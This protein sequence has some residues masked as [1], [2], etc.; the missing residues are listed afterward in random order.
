MKTNPHTAASSNIEP[1]NIQSRKSKPNFSQHKLSH[2]IASAL[3]AATLLTALPAHATEKDI[4]EAKEDFPI[5]SI[6]IIGRL[7]S[8]ASEAMEERREQIA[9]ADIMGIEQLAR[10]GDSD[11]A[12][13]LRRVTGLT[14][15][16]GKFIYV[17]GLGERYSS[18]SLNGAIVPSPDPTRNVVP[19][20]MFPSSVIES[21]SVQKSATADMPAAFGGGH[22][23]IRT[24]S[25][26]LEPFF[27]VAVGTAHNTNDSND[28][29]SYRGGNDNSG[30]DDGLR[31]LPSS[32]E[33]TY[34]QYG[35]ISP[36]DIVTGSA[37]N[38]DFTAAQQLNR[39][40]ALDIYRDMDITSEDTDQGANIDLAVGSNWDIGDESVFGVLAAASYKKQAKNYTKREVELDGDD[41]QAQIENSKNVNG[42]DASVRLSA[43]LNLGFELN[44]D[45]KIETFTTYLR[46]TSDDVSISIEE[47]V[48]TLGEPNALQVYGVNYEERSLI[49]NQIKGQH[50]LSDWWDLELAWQYSDA[51][52][53]R[54]APNELGYTYNVL[55]DDNDAITSRHLNTQDAPKYVYSQLDDDTINYGWS[56]TLPLEFDITMVNVKGGYQYFERTR[57]SNA[58]R[59]GF[60]VDLRPSD[61]DGNILAQSFGDI[62]SDDNITND[63]LG[64]ELQDAS[65]DTED[66]VAAEIIDAAFVSVDL[67]IDDEWRIYA[68]LRYEDFRRVTL[69]IDPDGDISDEGGRYQITDYIIKQDD[70]YPS[71][72]LTWVESDET[73]WRLGLSKTVVRPDLR[74]VSPV[75][76]QDPVTGFDFFG[77]P[78]LESS[79]IYNLDARWEWY[80][81][82]GNSFSVG[83]FYKDIDAP[84]E[85]I[86]RISEAGRQLKFYNADSGSIYGIEADFLQHLDVLGD[87]ES[88]W[89]YFF[90]TGNVTLSDSEINIASSGE[91]DPTNQT[92]RMTGHSQW[93][94]NLQLSFDSPSEAHSATLVYNVFGE[95]IAY[96]GRGGLDDV[97][98]QPFHSLDLSYSYFPTDAMAIKLK[99]QNLLDETAEYLQQG[100]QVYAKD[101]GS[102]YSLQFSYKF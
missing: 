34:N 22:V 32:I 41:Q 66:Y 27:S 68:G 26:P 98:E 48:D 12:A 18:T 55:L 40:L 52:S 9:V 1:I 51:S 64:L 35:G 100:Q 96:G 11:A 58:T 60:D 79:D 76:F 88:L 3:C 15:K 62:F 30:K 83:A 6:A 91:I 80:G 94:T 5:E 23:D 50:Y 69:P 38:I 61:S 20:D 85:P 81:E 72:S 71:L 19:L 21:L 25:I 37:G 4:D 63:R 54:A 29:L 78:Q 16:D 56:L 49:S 44:D 36:I 45:H 99:A 14:L 90:V 57:Q 59:L 65:T 67:N 97:V 39:E 70:W 93:V 92:R 89:Q 75:R 73:Q 33:Q 86:Q 87:D 13:A 101:P 95:R 10:T 47:T 31:D 53:S 84:I 8:A 77:N 28:A 46:D 24:K 7:N 74:E 102:Q 43:M 82:A 17:R 42:T 2:A